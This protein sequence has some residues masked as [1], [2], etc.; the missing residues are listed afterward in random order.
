MRFRKRIREKLNHLEKEL[1]RI[2][3]DLTI[4]RLEE[5][6]HYQIDFDH[7]TVTVP[8]DDPRTYE[9]VLLSLVSANIAGYP[10]LWR[11][12]PLLAQGWAILKGCTP[13]QP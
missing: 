10:N 1:F 11:T 4:F 13:W 12:S 2:R 3:K 8:E 7:Q 9:Q 6:H 5:R